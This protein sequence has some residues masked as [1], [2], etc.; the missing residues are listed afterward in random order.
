MAPENEARFR[1]IG[2]QLY[3]L[4]LAEIQS[5]AQPGDVDPALIESVVAT[6][7][8]IALDEMRRLKEGGQAD[9]PAAPDAEGR[10]RE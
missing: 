10:A 2:N 3:A 1:A 7:M 4:I 9:A 6:G 8:E 5:K